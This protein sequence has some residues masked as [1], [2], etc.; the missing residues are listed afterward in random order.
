MIIEATSHHQATRIVEATGGTQLFASPKKDKKTGLMGEP[1]KTRYVDIGPD[2]EKHRAAIEKITVMHK[3]FDG[4]THTFAETGKPGNQQ[5]TGWEPQ[6][7]QYALDPSQAQTRALHSHAGGARYAYNTM[8]AYVKTN[9]EQRDA[10]KTYGIAENDLT[11]AASWSFQSLRNEWNRRKHRLAVD[12]EN[13]P[14]WHTNSKEAYANSIDALA[15]ALGNWSKSKKGERRGQAMGFPRYKTR[16]NTKK[17][18][19]TTGSIRL[20]PTR[21]HVTLPVLGTIHTHESTRKLAR[22]LDKDNAR[23]IKATVRYE[24]CRWLVSYTCMVRRTPPTSHPHANRKTPVIGIDAGLKDL[25]VVADTHG[26][27]ILRQPAPKNF[28]KTKKKMRALQRKAARQQGPWD[29]D[30]KTWR[31]PS[32]GWTQTQ[33]HIRRTHARI[34]NLRRDR[35]HKLTTR[36]AATYPVIGGETLAVKNMMRRPKPKPERDKPGSFLPNNAKAKTGLARGFGDAALGEMYRQLEYKTK[37]YGGQLIRA[38]QFYPSSKTCSDCG[39]VK[40]KLRLNERT[41]HCDACGRDP[42][43]RDRNAAINLAKNAEKNYSRASSTGVVTGGADRKSRPPQGQA[44]GATA[45]A[46]QGGGKETGTANLSAGAVNIAEGTS[47]GC[48]A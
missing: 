29:P 10:E 4:N 46:H 27:E 44:G 8:L 30:T 2:F 45:T 7:Y 26:N 34:A 9:Q 14:W 41:F 11:P 18:T 12:T 47:T 48:A 16:K 31:D 33:Q 32:H 42:I 22:R 38:D 40:T 43:C 39:V 25:L 20:E 37:R 35:L 6:G 24:R 21:R 15:Q 19:F 13:N 36:L 1:K 3:L 28:E 23:I 17:F 5:H